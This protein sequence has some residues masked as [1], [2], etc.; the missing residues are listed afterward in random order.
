MLKV[1]S[2]MSKMLRSIYSSVKA[3]VKTKSG[4]TSVFNCPVGVRQG[5]CI[6]PILFS[7]FLNDL[8]DFVSTDS[9]GIDLDVCKIFLLLFADDLVLLAET[10]IELQRLLNKLK[11]FCTTWNLQ[12]NLNKTNVIV[13]RNGGY[14]RRYEKWFYGD[15]KLKVVTYYKYLGLVLSSRLSWYMCQKTLAEQA[16][17]AVFSLKSNLKKFG[18]L[19]A[20]LLLKIFDTKIM[21]ILTYA[22]EIW[23]SHESLDV[24]KI[25]HDFCK[26]ILRIPKRSP[27]IF[28]RGELGR[29]TI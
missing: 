28:A 7:F 10:K 8:K 21:P 2:K 23:F 11:E 26:Y 19:L 20:N 9:Y 29:H 6:S 18:P 3:C 12:V 4:L 27:N 1:S 25:H 5:C 14:L 17:K 13:F 22:A 16:S 24:E 15:T